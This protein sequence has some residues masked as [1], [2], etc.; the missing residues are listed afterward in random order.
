MEWLL[1]EDTDNSSLIAIFGLALLDSARHKD[2]QIAVTGRVP[3]G[4]EIGGM[5][6]W[7]DSKGHAAAKLCTDGSMG[8]RV[9]V[10]SSS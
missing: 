6:E 9:G 7:L 2:L 3:P 5:Q 10:S 4:Y 8:R 1:R